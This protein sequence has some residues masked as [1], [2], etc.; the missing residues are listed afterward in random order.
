[1]RPLTSSAIDRYAS[2]HVGEVNITVQDSRRSSAAVAAVREA[3]ADFDEAFGSSLPTTK[4]ASA[5]VN[6]LQRFNTALETLRSELPGGSIAVTNRTSRSI[7]LRQTFDRPIVVGYLSFDIPIF[8]GGQLGTRPVATTVRLDNHRW[9]DVAD[10]LAYHP[11]SNSMLERWIEFRKG[12]ER[13]A[14]AGFETSRVK[15]DGKGN[16]TNDEVS[17]AEIAQELRSRLSRPLYKRAIQL[18][19]EYLFRPTYF[20]NLRRWNSL[21]LNDVIRRPPG[22]PILTKGLT[23]HA[24][25][26]SNATPA[27]TRPVIE[28]TKSIDQPATRPLRQ[29][30]TD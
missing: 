25:T 2:Y 16:S 27:S 18:P 19:I 6:E 15:Q 4:Q 9:G 24:D 17:S 5:R 21:I 12:R 26:A 13:L 14:S 1:M 20:K 11:S 10:W 28:Q 3:E 7:S 29:R 8:E 22:D 30:T 23:S